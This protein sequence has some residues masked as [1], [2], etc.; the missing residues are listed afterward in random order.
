MKNLLKVERA[1]RNITQK[2]L[3]H[4]VGVNPATINSI[5]TKVYE[6]SILLCMKLAIYFNMRVEE[7]FTLDEE[8]KKLNELEEKKPRN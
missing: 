8:E 1:R 6:P 3:A 7:L 2:Q 4:V 5:E